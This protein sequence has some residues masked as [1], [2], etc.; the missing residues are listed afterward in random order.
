MK[1]GRAAFACLLPAF[2][3]TAPAVSGGENC[4]QGL[5]L[6]HREETT[7]EIVLYCGEKEMVKRYRDIA[8]RFADVSRAIL[9]I[10]QELER[11]RTRD[12]PDYQAAFEEWLQLDADAQGD[13]QDR[14]LG[15]VTTL[16]VADLTV[17][18]REATVLGSEETKLLIERYAQSPLGSPAFERLSHQ[19]AGQARFIGDCRTYGELARAVDDA[20]Q[21]VSALHEQRRRRYARALVEVAGLAVHD[22]RLRI[23]AAD[24]DFGLA[25]LLANATDQVA[26]DRIDALLALGDEKLRAVTSLSRTMRSLIAERDGLET[27]RRTILEKTRSGG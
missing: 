2:L 13:L 1:R 6:V 5:Q 11:Y 12:L 17:A 27:E 26:R 20:S 10:R 24:I 4:P 9:K 7:T 22:P 14:S 19:I 23:L 15:L 16:I 21:V 3:T 18:S 25:A 8:S